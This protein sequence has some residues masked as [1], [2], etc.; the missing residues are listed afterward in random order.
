MQEVEVKFVPGMTG[1][2]ICKQFHPSAKI[3]MDAMP[4]RL[5]W[6]YLCGG[7]EGCN[8]PVHWDSVTVCP[9]RATWCMYV[10][11]T[12]RVESAVKMSSVLC[13]QVSHCQSDAG[14]G[15]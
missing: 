13:G 1:L 7:C 4:I 8:S 9:E 14:G 5:G 2:A 12:T 10:I 15:T 6:Q 11:T 3:V